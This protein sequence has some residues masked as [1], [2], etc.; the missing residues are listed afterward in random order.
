[1]RIFGNCFVAALLM[2]CAWNIDAGAQEI[3]ETAPAVTDELRER[4]VKTLRDAMVN[5]PRWVKVHAAEH[6]LSLG[7]P[8]DVAVI[9]MQELELF[10]SEP[11]YRIGIWRVLARAAISPEEK[12]SW[13]ANIKEAFLDENGSDR[14]H[15]SETLAKL[16]VVIDAENRPAYFDAAEKGDGPFEAFTRCLLIHSGESDQESVLADLLGAPDERTRQCAAYALRHVDTVSPDTLER[17]AATWESESGDSLAKVYLLGSLYQHTSDGIEAA[18]LKV[19]LLRYAQ[20][21]NKGQKYEAIAVLG[22]K[23]DESDLPTLIALLDDPEADVRVGAAHAILRIERRVAHSLDPLDWLAIIGYA[24]MMLGVGWYYSRR[25]KT[26]E[27]YTLGGRNMRPFIVGLSMFATLLSTLTYLAIPG[28]MIKHGPMILSQYAIYPASFLVI[29]FVLIPAIMEMRV[30]SAYEILEIKLGLSVRI[31]GSLFFLSMRFLWMALIIYATSSKILVPLMHWDQSMV[32]VVCIV[33]GIITVAYTSMG[34]IRAVVITD[35]IQTGIL[36]FGAALTLSIITFKMGG[37]SEWFPLSWDETWD[38]LKIVYDPSVRLTV[39]GAMTSSFVWYICTAGA[40]QVAIQRYL[41]TRD[42]KAARKVMLTSLCTDV[43]TGTFLG[44]LGL[45]LWSYFQANPQFLPDAY[46]TMQSADTLFPRFIAQGLPAGIS[47]LIVAGLLAAAMSS[48]SSG[49]N[50]SSSVIAIDFIGR[51]R[52]SDQPKSEKSALREMKVVSVFVGVAVILLSVM[53]GTV[54][55]NL[56][57][58]MF[59]LVNLL[60]A[61]L[62]VLFVMALFVPWA[63]T[64]GAIAGGLC[65]VAMAIGIAYFNL[66]GLQFIWI[67]PMALLTGVVVGPTVSLL[68]IGRKTE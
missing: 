38:P 16:D 39:M 7:Y 64:T 25:I 45:A 23:G 30:T 53:V 61:P 54:G 4:A 27:E 55:G 65:S 66:F 43:L 21:G 22:E 33:M 41:S 60:V 50:S 42:A 24:S 49:V 6:L 34:G 48:L 12:E 1:M 20:T 19:K 14:L 9:F 32:P 68:P 29:G 2:G 3:S 26:T 18:E 59:K 35:A 40:D 52:R 67:M 5:E 56:L 44:M 8:Q 36:F 47:G 58:M 15:A 17:L 11:E 28:E 46:Q 51:F 63:T 37:V 57:E 13:I 31:L 10:G 62:F